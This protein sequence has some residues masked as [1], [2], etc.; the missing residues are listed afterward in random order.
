MSQTGLRD[1]L[2]NAFKPWQ[3]GIDLHPSRTAFVPRTT[4]KGTMTCMASLPARR[5]TQNPLKSVKFPPPPLSPARKLPLD[6]AKKQE[7][8]I[9]GSS[10]SSAGLGTGTTRGRRGE[11]VLGCPGW[12]GRPR[13]TAAPY[14]P[15]GE[16]PIIHPAGEGLLTLR[17]SRQ[18]TNPSSFPP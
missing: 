17:C 1:S 3:T 6:K 4:P 12:P 9:G 7:G 14:L 5:I 8:G 10:W 15:H 16:I 11:P 18:R 13:R 2:H